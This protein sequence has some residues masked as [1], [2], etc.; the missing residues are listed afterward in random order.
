MHGIFLHSIVEYIGILL[1]ITL[2]WVGACVIG[3]VSV[4][5]PGVWYI[6]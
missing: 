1:L 4:Y 6:G 2:Y 5:K 3:E